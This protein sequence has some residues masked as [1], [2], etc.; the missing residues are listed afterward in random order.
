[1]SIIY[2]YLI[3]PLLTS[4]TVFPLAL[5]TLASFVDILLVAP[6]HFLEFSHNRSV[7]VGMLD[8]GSQLN[9][10]DKSVL[11]LLDYLSIFC[12][13]WAFQ[14]VQGH[15]STIEE[16]IQFT[17]LLANGEK[18]QVRAAVVDSIPCSIILGQPFPIT[19]QMI[20]DPCNA[21]IQ[22]RKG[23]VK[24]LTRQQHSAIPSTV[25]TVPTEEETADLEQELNLDDSMLTKPQ[26]IKLRQLMHHYRKLWAGKHPGWVKHVE[27]RIRVNTGS[28]IRDNP[29]YHTQDQNAEIQT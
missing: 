6:L 3:L 23:P 5:S 29:R 7:L 22:T 1:M 13:H 16:W 2:S 18:L 12:P 20:Y 11:P 9:L 26:K 15:A 17:V 27:H 28:P 24:L 25:T 21:A 8:S 14:G 10:V 19:N 4:F